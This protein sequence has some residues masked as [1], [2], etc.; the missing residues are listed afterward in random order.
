MHN[1][2]YKLYRNL[3]IKTVFTLHIHV[4]IAYIVHTCYIHV[5]TDIYRQIY[6]CNVHI[7][8][9]YACEQYNACK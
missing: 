6:V 2:I 1:F 4:Q 7:L 3:N 8:C 9:Q 5:Y